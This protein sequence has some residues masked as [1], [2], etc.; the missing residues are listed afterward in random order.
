MAMSDEARRLAGQT[1]L[2]AIGERH[3]G[4]LRNA[5]EKARENADRLPKDLHW[6]EEPAHVYRLL[7]R[8]AVKP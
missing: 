5:I 8:K 2:D 3:Y 6:S 4:E 1:R 7:E